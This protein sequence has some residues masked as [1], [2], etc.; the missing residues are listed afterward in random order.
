MTFYI[1]FYSFLG[2]M[3]MADQIHFVSLHLANVMWMVGLFGCAGGAFIHIIICLFPVIYKTMQPYHKLDEIDRVING[4]YNAVKVPF[5]I[6]YTLLV[7]VSS[8]IVMYAT[9]RGYLHLS[10]WMM[11]LT[12]LST[13]LIGLILRV[14]FPRTCYD[15]PG[16]ILPSTGIGMIGLLAIINAL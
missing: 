7:G 3:A 8:L 9:F 1:A 10:Y 11:L 16:I 13:T 15:L 2:F 6:C 12:P 14:I 5:W 4:V